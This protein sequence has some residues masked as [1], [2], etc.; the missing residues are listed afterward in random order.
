[1]PTS[2]GDGIVEG[3][4]ECDDAGE[5]EDCNADCT[6]AICGDGVVNESAT[7]ECD[8]Q[9]ESSRCNADCTVASCGDGQTNVSAGEECDD[10]GESARCNVDCTTAVCGDGLI[11]ASA[12]EDC[13][14]MGESALCDDDC[15]VA[16]CG[17]GSTNMSAGEVC[18]DGG[19][20]SDCDADCTPAECGDGLFNAMAGELC[21]T[22][23]PTAMCDGDCTLVECGDGLVNGPAGEACDDA[24]E[25]SAC[26]ADCTVASCGDGITNGSA[27]EV[28][29]D[30]GESLTCDL[31]CTAV[32]CGDGVTN[33]AAGEACDD[34]GE[35]AGCDAD[36]T[37]VVCG[38]GIVNPVAGEECEGADLQGATCSSLGFTDGQLVCSAACTFDTNAC[39][40]L[41]GVPSLVLDLAQVKQFEFSWASV[42]GADYY[43]L[44]QSVAP[45]EPFVQL[46][47]DIMGLSVSHSMP[48]H[49]R[50]E[51]SYRLL[52]CNGAG[53][54][55]SVPVDV[56]GTMVE[57]VGYFK[58][59]NAE[60]SD[61]F[62]YRLSISDDGT[63]LAVGARFEDSDASGVDGDQ[64]SNA[65]IGS[66]AV[67]VFT[68]DG[69]GTW[70]Q[71]AYVKASTP[72]PHD[73]FGE[74]GIALSSDGTTLAVGA[75]SEDS[76]ATGVDGDQLDDTAFDSG[77][78]YVF[79]RDGMGTWSQQAYV[80][81]SNTQNG[82]NFGWS[83]ALSGDGNTL[84]VGSPGE[85]SDAT[86]ID[87][88]QLDDTAF[89]SGAVYLFTRDGMG[90]WSQ[91]TYVK[92]SNT[93]ISDYFGWSIALAQDGSTLAVTAWGEDSDATGV[94]GDQAD[95]SAGSAGATYVFH[96]DGMGIWSQQAYVKAS[97]A[98]AN[99]HFGWDVSLTGDGSTMAVGARREDSSATGVDGLEASNA[100][101][102]S[103]AAYVYM[104]DGMGAWS[105]QAYLKA[106]NPHPSDY[107]GHGVSLSSDGG[108]LAIAALVEASGADGV[109]GDQADNSTNN[110]GAVYVFEFDG[111][112]SWAQQAYVKASNS[113]VSDHFGYDL[114]LDGSGETLAVGAYGE[115]SGAT[116]LGGDQLDDAHPNTGAV[117]LY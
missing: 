86:G 24:G 8:D 88:D 94:G 93:A 89:N 17:D 59:S 55:E 45:G 79:E 49:Y 95:N 72:G 101:M 73:H 20:S 84:A 100:F 62:G 15:S 6:Q 32:A 21:D 1:M 51:A 76:N 105:Q 114:A 82:G 53:C 64:A 67:Y 65:L 91:Q 26:N 9:R 16:M 117:Y 87:G 3:S 31:D 44:E 60:A 39:N 111:M 85:D 96:R 90:T 99:D 77:A 112:G 70:V 27:G 48:L 103:G 74:G 81:A 4:E 113:G 92:S 115:G 107:F 2:C 19:K 66:G 25:S 69:A 104:R 22:A 11:N 63:T 29:D 97:N 23:G 12:G 56:M 102:D 50:Y 80:K 54:M 43:Q 30:M 36:C 71:Q 41:P 106:S 75:F 78:V 83:V 108:T 98:Q 5:S 14:D 40:P 46:G 58:A 34:A 18:D 61:G 52:A 38:D 33:M 7:E 28:C 57:A 37:A 10:G 42:P 47:A 35:S 116:G 110:A 68:R 109:E 13:D